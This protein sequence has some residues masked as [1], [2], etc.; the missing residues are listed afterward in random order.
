MDWIR[1][2]TA[3][4]TAFGDTVAEAD[5]TAPVPACP[6]WSLADLADHL[7]QIHQWAAHAVVEVTPDGRPEPAPH[8]RAALAGW[9]RGHAAHL[10]DVLTEAGPDAPAWTFD[11][12]DATASFWRRRQVHETA[13]HLWDARASQ[14]AAGS[15]APQLALD[16][17]HEVATVFFPRQVRLERL[18]PLTAA[19]GLVPAEGEPLVLAGDGTTTPTPDVV[20]EADAQTL[21]LLL[22]HRLTLDDAPATVVGDRQLAADLLGSALTP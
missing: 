15:F 9:Y 20:V 13:M 1:E 16:G 3:A 2:L 21:L 19:L 5:L 11:P 17:V 6:G 12:A 22:W 7:G 18:A 14:G 8:G 4:T 10:V